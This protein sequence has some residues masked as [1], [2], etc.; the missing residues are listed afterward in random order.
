ML[1][2]GARAHELP[3]ASRAPETQWHAGASA[4]GGLPGGP[5]AA[6]PIPAAARTA[7]GDRAGAAELGAPEA[8][9][10]GQGPL[11][12]AHEAPTA[13]GAE[14]Q[15]ERGAAAE[16]TAAAHEA[17]KRL[18]VRLLQRFSTIFDDFHG[19]STCFFDDYLIFHRFL[20]AAGSR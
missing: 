10:Q 8:W 12:G 9:G 5:P 15:E 1:G 7:P 20:A 3:S 6:L 13:L 11:G 18:F 19:F 2:L 14:L 4:P 16:E 17:T